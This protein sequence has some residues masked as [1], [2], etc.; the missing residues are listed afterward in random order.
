V[1]DEVPSLNPAEV[2]FSQEEM[3][4]FRKRLDQYLPESAEECRLPVFE[5]MGNENLS[6]TTQLERGRTRANDISRTRLGSPSRRRASS[7]PAHS[8]ADHHEG[9]SDCDRK[10]K[11]LEFLIDTTARVNDYVENLSSSAKEAMREYYK[12][13]IFHPMWR[14]ASVTEKSAKHIHT[15]LTIKLRW[16]ISLLTIKTV[17]V[18]SADIISIGSNPLKPEDQQIADEHIASLGQ[19][20]VLPTARSFDASPYDPEIKSKIPPHYV[21]WNSQDYFN[22]LLSRKCSV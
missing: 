22:A 9:S 8:P 13:R 17:L 10:T 21:R 7:L 20:P 18:K 6:L 16:A 11:T 1:Q 5:F 2:L 4:D 12:L 15:H 14:N 19:A 3:L